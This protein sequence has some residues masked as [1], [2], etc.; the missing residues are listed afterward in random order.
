MN[1]ILLNGSIDVSIEDQLREMGFSAFLTKP[2]K[3]SHLLDCITEVVV[4]KRKVELLA[5]TTL[6]QFNDVGLVLIADDYSIN[7]QVLQMYLEQ[8]GL[9]YHMA[10][11]GQEVVDLFGRTQ[12]S[13]I[14]MDC[15]MPVLDGFAA[16]KLIR[17]Q[18]SSTGMHTPI[19]A[20]TA[21]AMEGDRERCLS[22]GMD[23]YLTKPIEQGKLEQILRKW[24]PERNTAASEFATKPILNIAML[25]TR[26]DRADLC[27]LIDSFCGEMDSKVALIEEA[28]SK[29]NFIQLADV[30]HGIRGVS[31][32]LCAG[33]LRSI[34]E[35]IEKLDSK[36]LDWNQVS[37]L[38]KQFDTCLD[39]TKNAM[40]RY[41]ENKD[42]SGNAG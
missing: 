7:R 20:L 6:Q 34:C 5:K 28:I 12:Y 1:L 2:V 25:E 26:F 14:L 3:Q 4:G 16:T 42:D 21:Y 30:I 39:E 35:L 38:K 29:Q 41:V 13:L 10:V 9:Q 40:R 15:Q 19:I 33:Q 27:A 17:K 8:L 22:A 11:N 36:D 23:D 31:G 32:V 18:E 24:L 37:E